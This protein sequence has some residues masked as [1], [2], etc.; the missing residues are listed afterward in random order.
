MAICDL[1]GEKV[2]WFHSR[3]AECVTR[4]ESLQKT[5]EELAFDGTIAGSTHADLDAEARQLADSSHIRFD[6]FREALLQGANDAAS[7]IA[8]QSPVSQDEYRRV[9]D[10]LQ[11]WGIQDYMRTAT[12]FIHRQWFGLP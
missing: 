12:D 5:L 10:I 3:H 6:N 1:C 4:A 7:K 9:L 2:G 8:L 11:G